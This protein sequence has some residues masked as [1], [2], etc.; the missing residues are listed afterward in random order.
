MFFVV[1]F[2]LVTWRCIVTFNKAM[3]PA[4]KFNFEFFIAEATLKNFAK[5]KGK[6]LYWSLFIIKLSTCRPAKLSKRDPSPGVF[7]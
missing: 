3:H 6:H 5:L 7:L 1:C 4:S 2:D